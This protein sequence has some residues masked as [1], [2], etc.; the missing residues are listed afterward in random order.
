MP[1]WTLFTITENLNPNFFRSSLKFF[2]FFA[3]TIMSVRPFTEGLFQN[4]VIFKDL[5]SSEIQH[6]VAKYKMILQLVVLTRIPFIVVP[7]YKLG[8]K[9]YFVLADILN[10]KNLIAT[11]TFAH[12]WAKRNRN[13]LIVLN[14]SLVWTKTSP[15]TNLAWFQRS[16]IH[17]SP[18]FIF[19]NSINYVS[20]D[21]SNKI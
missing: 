10:T 13:G 3:V 11:K 19:S 5:E 8:D 14:T 4:E 21:Q 7:I 6:D 1:T 2:T 17:A 16:F 20:S 12:D 15:R 9:L 18:K